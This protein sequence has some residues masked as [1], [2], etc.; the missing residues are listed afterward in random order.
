MKHTPG[1]WEFRNNGLYSGDFAILWATQDHNGVEYLG[2][3]EDD[4]ELITKAP[5]MYEILKELMD[6]ADPPPMTRV[7]TAL[8]A[9][10]NALAAARDLLRDLNE[11]PTP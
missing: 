4:G 2:L 3:N 6:C 1:P 8:K 5:E 11:R 9:L 7:D 10:Q